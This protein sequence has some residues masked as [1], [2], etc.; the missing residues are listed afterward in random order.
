MKFLFSGAIGT[1]FAA[2]LIAGIVGAPRYAMAI[3]VPNILIL[4]EDAD[5]DTVPRNSRIFRRALASI[6][7]QLNDAG[8]DVF[9]ETAITLNEFSQDRVRRTDAEIIDVAKSIRRPPIDVAVIFT[10]YAQD[11]ARAYT[12]RVKARIVG[13]MINVHSGQNLGNFEVETPRIWN[14]PAIC[15][16]PCILESA[17]RLTQ[18]LSDDLGTMLAIRLTNLVESDNGS[19]GQNAD[20]GGAYSLVFKGFNSDE[21]LDVVEYLVVFSGYKNHRPVFTASRLQEIWYDSSSTSQR[22]QRNITK[23]IDFM[24]VQAQVR[25]SG[26]EFSIQKIARR[27]NLNLDPGNFN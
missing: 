15:D 8:F 5:T 13:R 21:M 23:M 10:I 27:R 6:A 20:I 12:T 26:N 2:F 17:G 22:L 3:D 1:A 19:G 24:G 18:V 4:G 7:N 16:R 14:A 25:F 9:D 11:E